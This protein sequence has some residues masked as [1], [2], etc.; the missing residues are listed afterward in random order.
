MRY[1]VIQW[2]EIQELMNK[3][4]FKENSFLVNDPLGLD[5][6][7]SSAYFVNEGWLNTVN[8]EHNSDS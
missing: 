5:E 8:N 3:E 7:G 6:F 2:P 1:I 4:R